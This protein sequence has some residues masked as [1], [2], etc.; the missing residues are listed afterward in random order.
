MKLKTVVLSLAALI[1]TACGGSGNGGTNPIESKSLSIELQN[2]IV[3]LDEGSTKN[4]SFSVNYTGSDDLA[5]DVESD[6]QDITVSVENKVVKITSPQIDSPLTGK[7]TITATDGRLNDSKTFTVNVINLSLEELLAS[8]NEYTKHQNAY[9]ALEED[10][11]LA[12]FYGDAAYLKGLVSYDEGIALSNLV[13]NTRDKTLK[14]VKYYFVAL[15][16]KL[17]AYNNLTVTES[18]LESAVAEFTAALSLH[19]KSTATEINNFNNNISLGFPLLD[20]NNLT[21]HQNSGALGRLEDDKNLGAYNNE[22]WTFNENIAWLAK[23]ATTSSAFKTC[24]TGE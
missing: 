20:E 7:I 17:D 3:S 12:R 18:E 1:L 4:I 10:I 22:I 16:Q 9:D 24:S 11:R 2:N 13:K 5:Y 6:H 23:L 8:F 14:D 15:Q 21:Y 19:A